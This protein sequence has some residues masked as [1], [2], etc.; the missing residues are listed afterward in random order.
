M[1]IYR[2]RTDGS[3]QT[4]MTDNARNNWFAHVSPDG[5]KVVYLSY[6]EGDLDAAEHLPNMQVELWLMNADGSGKKRI[7][8]FFGGQGSINVNSWAA[9]SRRF[10]F[11]S[12]DLLHS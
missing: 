12:Y 7:L 4:Q 5:K 8:S 1:Q 2:M 10:A 3:E 11:V 9:D 6:R